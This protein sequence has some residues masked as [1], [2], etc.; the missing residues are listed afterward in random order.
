MAVENYNFV[1]PEK[2]YLCFRW[3]DPTQR[4]PTGKFFF[5][6]A[7]GKH[8]SRFLPIS[9]HVLHPELFRSISVNSV[10]AADV[11]Q[12]LEISVCVIVD[13][14]QNGGICYM[15]LKSNTK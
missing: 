7:V 1:G 12:T 15:F 14:L 10:T 4:L 9:R 13:F 5:I 6:F 11:F 3:P 2:K 8:F